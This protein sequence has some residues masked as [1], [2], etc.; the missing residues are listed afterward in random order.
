LRR[1]CAAG[2][3]PLASFENEGFRHAPKTWWKPT[4]NTLEA[5]SRSKSPIDPALPKGDTRS[6]E[7]VRARLTSRPTSLQ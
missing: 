7:A 4:L 1:R 6:D 3:L 2:K 5:P